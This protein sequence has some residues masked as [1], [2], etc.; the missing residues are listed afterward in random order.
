MY[1]VK[2]ALACVVAWGVAKHEGALG[3]FATGIN[4][5]NT[6]IGTYTFTYVV[7]NI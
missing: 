7:N 2:I 5:Q 1:Y 6:P 3:C 4:D